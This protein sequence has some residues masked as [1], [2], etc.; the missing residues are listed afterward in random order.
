MYRDIKGS[1]VLVNNEEI[2]KLADFGVSKRM[3]M[4]DNIV[5]DNMECMMET[6]TMRD[7]PYFMAPEVLFVNIGLKLIYGQVEVLHI[8]CAREKRHGKT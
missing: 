4:S 2:V 1:N 7:T 8:K 3:N 5:V 6:I